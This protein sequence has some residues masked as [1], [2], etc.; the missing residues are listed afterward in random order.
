VS[1]AA[2]RDQTTVPV[3][4]SSAFKIPVAPSE[5]TRPLL[6]VGVPRGPAPPFDS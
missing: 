2:L 4:A 1:D 5:Y 6:S 3:R